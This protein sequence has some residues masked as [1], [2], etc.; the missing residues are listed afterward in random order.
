MVL[1][2]PVS[3]SGRKVSQVSRQVSCYPATQDGL[4]AFVPAF[5]DIEGFL[6]AALVGD[7]ALSVE[8]VLD[9]DYLAA[10]R[11]EILQYPRRGSCEALNPVQHVHA[12]LIKVFLIFFG[13]PLIHIPMPAV[14][15]TASEFRHE[16]RLLDIE[17]PVH[18]VAFL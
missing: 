16:D 2:T 3:L 1:D 13:K 14:D 4:F 15:C 7:Q 9:A 17:D 10:W 8:V 11:T 12:S 18:S 5:H 6:L